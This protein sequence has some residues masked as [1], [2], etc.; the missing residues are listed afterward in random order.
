MNWHF[1]PWSIVPILLTVPAAAYLAWRAWRRRAITGTGFMLALIIWSILA[2]IEDAQGSLTVKL[3]CFNLEFVCYALV[4]PLWLAIVLEG[5]GQQTS[6][7]RTTTVLSS[8]PPIAGVLLC[9]TNSVHHLIY[10][11][12]TLAWASGVPYLTL[13]YATGFWLFAGYAYLLIL[14]GVA[15]CLISFFSTHGLH[16]RQ[17]LLLMLGG[18]VPAIVSYLDSTYSVLPAYNLTPMA[19]L[20]TGATMLLGLHRYRL[21]EL[22]PL[23]YRTIFR[24]IADGV[25][26]VDAHCRV[27]EVNPAGCAILGITPMEAPGQSFESFFTRLPGVTRDDFTTEDR[28]TISETPHNGGRILDI[29]ITPLPG[30]PQLPPGWLVVLRDLSDLRKLEQQ[31]HLLTSYDALTGLPNR[32]LLHDRLEQAIR[33]GRRQGT[34]TGLLAL[35]LDHFTE[36]NDL[37]GRGVGDELLGQVAG[38]LQHA[39][40]D[41]DTVSRTNGIEFMLVIADLQGREQL[42]DIAQGLLDT[43][44]TS[45]MVSGTSF[46]LGVHM[47]FVSAPD[48]G[49]C[50]EVLIKKADVVLGQAR[51]KD[52][53]QP[54]CFPSILLPG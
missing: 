29:R 4:P 19:F 30:A 21:W 14:A 32:L 11:Q 15:A 13:T 6:R 47:G 9:W 52:S 41:C 35:T 12:A 44:H 54:T 51:K 38:R 36:I 50:A 37:Y 31:F 17:A 27:L 20:V 1:Y 43:I 49:L 53:G 48:D 34:H 26:I 5:L 28:H 24:R 33:H 16:R 40:R 22:T 39:V 42:L 2:G 7:T 3:A 46:T 18:I 8:L 23:V 10:T 25:F 45:Y